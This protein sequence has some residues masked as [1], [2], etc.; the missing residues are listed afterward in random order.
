[1]N[2]KE[3]ML[4]GMLYDPSDPELFGKRTKAHRLWKQFNDTFEDE[5]ERRNTLLHDLFGT[6]G[7]GTYISSPI[8]I[9]YGE[10]T[11]FGTNCFT[12]FNLTV[13][14][15]CPV[16][17]GNDVFI[18]PNVSLLTPL[19]PLLSEDRRIHLRKSGTP[20]DLEY[21]APITI[22]DGVWLAGDVKVCGGVTI[23]KGSV[24]GAG[25]IVTRSIPAGVL[26][27]GNP[28]RVIRELTEEDAV[29]RKPE[30]FPDGTVPK[31]IFE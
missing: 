1:M 6:L 10:F 31:T 22:E 17:I 19:H 13:L 2:E 15:T 14:D 5:E 18:G 30:L 11:H 25:S 26:A 12:N 4:A 7:E 20:Y 9:D 8:Y 23:G 28:C 29:S 16:H 21:G 27:A 24:I 3:K